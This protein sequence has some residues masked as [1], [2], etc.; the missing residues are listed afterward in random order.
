MRRL[1]G[2]VAAG[3]FVLL[4]A[5][6]RP[7]AGQEPA[8]PAPDGKALYEQHCR[9]CHGATGTPSERMVGMYETLKPL[10]QLTG[11]SAD[12]IVTLLV[13][14]GTEGMKSYKDKLTAAELKAVAEYTLTLSK[15][16]GS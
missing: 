5:A 9:R 12:S 4:A 14:G 16:Q 8:A 3:V 6:A 10:S 1:K 11:V 2:V 15:P 7:A 13:V